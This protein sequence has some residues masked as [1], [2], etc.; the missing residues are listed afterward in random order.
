MDDGRISNL[1][2][3]IRMGKITLNFQ[4]SLDGVVS[5]PEQWA[6]IDD[7]LLQ[8]SIER[9]DR[10]DAVIF[11]SKTYPGMAEYWENAEK[12]SENALTRELAQK[13]NEKKKYVVSRSETEI[14]WRNSEL[15]KFDGIESLAEKLEKLKS[16]NE[17]DITVESGLKLWQVFVQ[18]SLFDVICCQVHPVIAGAGEKLFGD[19]FKK[20]PL[21][22]GVTR[23]FDNGI[24]QM[25]YNKE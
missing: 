16:E 1:F 11:G 6:K 8:E 15:L 12:T 5:D 23:T 24:V 9:Y 20:T 13:L 21:R 2:G 14:V 3:V 22:L 18:N 4:I 19:D 10:L 17:K 25:N 7:I